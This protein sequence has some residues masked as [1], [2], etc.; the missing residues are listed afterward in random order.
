VDTTLSWV[1]KALRASDNELISTSTA[2]IGLVIGLGIKLDDWVGGVEGRTA[3]T[4]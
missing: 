1:E 3:E 2:K 4:G